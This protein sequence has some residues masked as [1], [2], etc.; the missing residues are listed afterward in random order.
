MYHRT[1][2][3]RLG[4]ERKCRSWRLLGGVGGVLAGGG[5]LVV[6]AVI[7]E[8]V[9]EVHWELLCEDRLAM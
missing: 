4:S 8:D 7:G 5:V 1:P 2:L 3:S 9:D 6:D